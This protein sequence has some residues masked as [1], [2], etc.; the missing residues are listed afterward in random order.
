M[1]VPSGL[2]LANLDY[3]RY[4]LKVTK[5]KVTKNQVVLIGEHGVLLST[6]K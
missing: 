6:L 2:G 1:I 3:G 4:H 5:D